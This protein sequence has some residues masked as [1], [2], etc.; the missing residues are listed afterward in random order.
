MIWW[1]CKTCGRGLK[2]EKKPNFCYYDRMSYI[3]NISD[4]DSVKMGLKFPEE[5]IGL[6][7]DKEVFFPE[8]FGDVKYLPYSGR[9][10]AFIAFGETLH[11]FQKRIMEKVNA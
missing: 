5:P 8:F 4:E 2:A 11:G 1:V 9:R 10:L 7:D 6:E 3:E